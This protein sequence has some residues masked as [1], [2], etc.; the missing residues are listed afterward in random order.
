M[1]R[2]GILNML[3]SVALPDV[4]RILMID[5]P[6]VL[7]AECR[8]ARSEHHGLSTMRGLLRQAMDADLIAPVP[9]D[10]M[11]HL[12]LAAAF[13]AADVI[14]TSTEPDRARQ[15]AAASIN[16]LLDSLTATR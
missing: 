14:A 4:Q 9:L 2:T 15:D 16:R 12:L 10:M 13:E 11:S 7:G 6:V 1:A 3:E 5:G 8:A